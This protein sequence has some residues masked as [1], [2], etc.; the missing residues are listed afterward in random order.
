M[1]RIRLKN[2]RLI[3]SD[4]F[5]VVQQTKTSESDYVGVVAEKNGTLPHY[6]I[7]SDIPIHDFKTEDEDRLYEYLGGLYPEVE[8]VRKQ[9]VEAVLAN[10][11]VVNAKEWDD[12]PRL[13]LFAV[14]DVPDERSLHHGVGIV[15][16]EDKLWSMK[17][18]LKNLWKK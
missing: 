7:F 1:Q 10:G 6:L 11:R 9:E 4:S 14:L 3:A 18:L 12:A 13:G 8:G 16:K 5:I 17:H 2:G 15:R